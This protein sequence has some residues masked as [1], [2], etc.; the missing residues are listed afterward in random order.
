LGFECSSQ[1][2]GLDELPWTRITMGLVAS[3]ETPAGC[4][5]SLAAQG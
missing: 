5:Y 4:V 1:E 2:L 3:I